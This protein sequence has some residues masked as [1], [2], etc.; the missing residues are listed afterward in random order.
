MT[1]YRY[2]I[3]KNTGKKIRYIIEDTGDYFVFA[4]RKTKY[5]YRMSFAEFAARY[6]ILPKPDENAEWHKRLATVISKL[7]I[8]GLWSEKLK[9][10]KN[11]DTMSKSDLDDINS[12]YR[13]PDIA[14]VK[15][16]TKYPFVFYKDNQN[17]QIHFDY[18]SELAD[19]R[20]KTMYFGKYENKEIKQNIESAIQSKTS[21][22][23]GRISVNYDVSFEYS[24]ER[25]MAW[26]SEEYKNCGNG[27]YYIAID[28]NT[29]V[30]MEND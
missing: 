25:N 11:L 18:I 26:Y 10:F 22:N 19:C 30:F 2:A 3:D 21:Y 6:K 4:P 7:E 5:G 17:I 12:L 16:G 24:A 1:K 20:L 29:A 27:H 14:Y 23:T 15:Y 9:F 8:S 28:K 13:T